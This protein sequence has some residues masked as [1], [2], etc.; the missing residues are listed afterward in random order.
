MAK[1]YCQKN[2]KE[3]LWLKIFNP[4]ISKHIYLIFLCVANDHYLGKTTLAYLPPLFNETPG[5]SVLFK[6]IITTTFFLETKTMSFNT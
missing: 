2:S 5:V 3:V 6:I 1:T 4:K